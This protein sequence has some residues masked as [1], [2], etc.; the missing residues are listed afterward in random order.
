VPFPVRL[1]WKVRLREKLQISY[2]LWL[3]S[4]FDKEKSNVFDDVA[5]YLLIP[6]TCQLVG[7]KEV[8][9]SLTQS[10]QLTPFKFSF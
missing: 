8:E 1:Q 9:I 10:F 5:L 4:V 2:V 3:G 7:K 6:A